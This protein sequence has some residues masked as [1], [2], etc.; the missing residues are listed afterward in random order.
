MATRKADDQVGRRSH[1]Q[2]RF[3]LAVNFLSV[4]VIWPDKRLERAHTHLE[5]RP[6]PRLAVVWSQGVPFKPYWCSQ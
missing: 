4:S 1:E 3:Y 2:G 5:P 6:D